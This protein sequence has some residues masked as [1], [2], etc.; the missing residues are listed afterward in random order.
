MSLPDP[1]TAA[2]LGDLATWANSAVSAL[3][4]T[5]AIIA[6]RYTA[7]AYRLQVKRDEKDDT[8]RRKQDALLLREQAA[9][10][11]GWIEFR[12][13]DGSGSPNGGWGARVRNASQTPVYQAKLTILNVHDADSTVDYAIPVIP[14]G[15]EPLFYRIGDTEPLSVIENALAFR[16]ELA[17]T[18]SSGTRWARDRQGRLVDLA[19]KLVL[20]A[21]QLR[22]DALRPFAENFCSPLGLTVEPRKVPFL[23]LQP[24]LMRAAD[25][26]RAQMPDLVVGAHDWIGNLVR[27]NVLEP[28]DFSDQRSQAFLPDAIEAVT[29]RGLRYGVPYAVESVAL[30][31][32]TKLV[33]EAPQTF[34]ELVEIV[35]RLRGARR[36]KHVLA[37]PIGPTGDAYHFHPLFTAAGGPPLPVGLDAGQ[38]E[39]STPPDLRFSS[40]ESMAAFA[41]I[42]ELGEAGS[43][44]LS[45]NA[46]EPIATFA[47][48][49]AAFLISG[50]WAL[51]RLDAAQIPYEI[52]PIPAYDGVGPAR[53]LMGVSAIFVPRRGRSKMIA[54]EFLANY[55]TRTDLA[56][57]LY[58]AEARPPAL[59]R[60]IERLGGVNPV[61]TAFLAA[62][63]DGVVMPSWPEVMEL[64]ALIG[65]AEAAIVGGAPVAP[66]VSSLAK[67]VSGLLTRKPRD[68]AR[69]RSRSAVPIPRTAE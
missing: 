55:L 16:V 66:T 1:L 60:A 68:A 3:A 56:M 25:D 35:R 17:F 22:V 61:M 59:N 18:D 21:D 46:P 50:P 28:V 64:F 38:R 23:D 20:W 6:G 12:S 26:E 48:G 51:A 36:V 14:P 7:R 27:A 15:G 57:E 58:R 19:E 9:L 40:P 39:V 31:R 37:V 45:R 44:V 11:S 52:T 62:A 33:P 24:E 4:L 13:T 53:P 32:N 47:N 54:H 65:K 34:E 43:G 42:A 8:E 5:A 67:E 29:Y 41:R 49:D 63:K 30:F 2:S 10:V 69:R